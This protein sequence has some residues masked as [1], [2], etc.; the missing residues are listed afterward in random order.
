[1]ANTLQDKM[2][3]IYE[4]KVVKN[5]NKMV[6]RAALSTLTGVAFETPVDTGQ[7]RANWNT[8]INEPD[9]TE[10]NASNPNS[11]A[12]E[13]INRGLIAVSAFKTE[14]TIRIT[15]N[16]PYIGELNNGSSQQIPEGFVERS[17]QAAIAELNEFKRRLDQLD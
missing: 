7:A 13:A 10:Y 15:N 11:A 9:L 14:D 6:R 2:N 16:M 17:V 5:M 12:D 8:A 3:K 4:E 1:M